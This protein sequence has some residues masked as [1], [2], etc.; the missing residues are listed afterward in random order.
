MKR[1]KHEDADLQEVERAL[2]ALA[3]KVGRRE[4]A[5]AR[6]FSRDEY[7]EWRLEPPVVINGKRQPRVLRNPDRTGLAKLL[8]KDDFHQRQKQRLHGRE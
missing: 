7:P 4:I 3:P 8:S 5:E 6:A 1:F 2:A